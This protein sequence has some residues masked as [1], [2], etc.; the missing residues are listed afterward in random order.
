MPGSG[1]QPCAT[2]IKSA[3]MIKLRVQKYIFREIIVPM[4]LGIF[5]L[6]FILVMGNL[7]KLTDLFINKGVPLTEIALLFFYIFPAFL[8]ITLAMAFLLG[9]LVGF[10]R[11]SADSEI[12][13][14]KASGVSIGTMLKPVLFLA[15]M[16]TLA[17]GWLLFYAKPASQLALRQQVFN[18]INNRLATGLQPMVFYHDFEGVVIYAEDVHPRT[19]RMEN[20][21]LC[22]HRDSASTATIFARKGYIFSNPKTLA[23]TFSLEDGTILHQPAK[24]SPPA[25]QILRFEGYDLNLS[26]PDK[27]QTNKQ[28]KFKPKTMTLPEIKTALDGNPSPTEYHRLK[29][30]WH[31]RLA[32][33]L[34]PFLFALVGVPL[35][36]HS[37]RSGKFGGFAVA[38]LIFLTYF[39]LSSFAETL[40]EDAEM[41]FYGLIW[42]PDIL[43]LIAGS[44]FLFCASRE[45]DVLFF[46]PNFKISRLFSPFQR[47]RRG[48][49]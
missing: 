20:I 36:I 12:I 13:A 42:A 16:V 9:I 19:G 10:G 1:L 34:V 22:D 45:K 5:V 39:V 47:F 14:L 7:L 37:P 48:K 25:V 40:C 18:I 44:F 43:F 27:N 46:L 29:I 41:A 8:D 24:A 35:G 31:K 30:E 28:S 33:T 49:K 4:G 15:L 17:T 2:V 38:L 6:S 26:F 23:F 21:F 32:L 11:L 3:C